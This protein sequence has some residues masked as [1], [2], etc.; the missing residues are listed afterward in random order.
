MLKKTT[1]M[2]VFPNALARSICLEKRF[3][4]YLIGG[5]FTIEIF[6]SIRA[7]FFPCGP[8][9]FLCYGTLILGTFG[10]SRVLN[11]PVTLVTFPTFIAIVMRVVKV[12]TTTGKHENSRRTA[13]R[14]D[15]RLGNDATVYL[16]TEM[17][18]QVLPVVMFLAGHIPGWRPFP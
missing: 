11:R 4:Y 17:N 6:F 18:R 2:S 10:P 5:I 12:S 3:I 7:Q 15:V 9:L 8:A 13:A 16:H 1:A 14:A